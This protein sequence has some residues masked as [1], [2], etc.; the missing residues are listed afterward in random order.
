MMCNTFCS[1]FVMIVNV[2]IK[3]ASH[4]GFWLL[5][6]CNSKKYEFYLQNLAS[7]WTYA[8]GTL[9]EKGGDGRG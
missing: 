3:P 5:W 4:Q 6:D 7:F 2:L 9:E 8:T 1:G